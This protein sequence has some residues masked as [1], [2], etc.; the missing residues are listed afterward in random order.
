VEHAWPQL[1]APQQPICLDSIGDLCASLRHG[2]IPLLRTGTSQAHKPCAL[3][4]HAQQRAASP[5][6]ADEDAVCQHGGPPSPQ[7]IKVEP[8]QDC[9]ACADVALCDKAQ[10]FKSPALTSL[11]GP[12]LHGASEPQ[13]LNSS[14]AAGESA[15]TAVLAPRSSCSS[16]AAMRLPRSPGDRTDSDEEGARRRR[17][18][19]D[20]AAPAGQASSAAAA[21]AEGAASAGESEAERQPSG[22][23]RGDVGTA[24][25]ADGGSASVDDGQ[26]QRE[27]P[28]VCGLSHTTKDCLALVLLRR[29]PVRDDGWRKLPHTVPCHRAALEFRS[30]SWAV[31][32]QQELLENVMP[33]CVDDS[34]SLDA[35]WTPPSAGAVRDMHSMEPAAALEVLLAW[36]ATPCSHKHGWVI[37]QN[38]SCIRSMH[39]CIDN[40]A[41]LV[42]SLPCPGRTHQP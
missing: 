11:A 36:V 20:A 35:A 22:D 27:S 41:L 40:A 37:R 9:N 23:T 31:C 34:P 14:P 25:G 12:Q 29:V 1:P 15:G 24:P 6:A 21:G 17:S 33:S 13:P 5:P 8:L 28:Q 32:M 30:R 18:P 38:K 16:E 42:V 2:I 26:G 7:G 10:L 19:P 3:R 4:A 39:G